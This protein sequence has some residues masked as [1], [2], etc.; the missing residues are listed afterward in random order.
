MSKE[1]PS[2]SPILQILHLEDSP[3][4]CD[5]VQEAV[6]ND[7]L[8]GEFTRVATQ[9]E[10]VDALNRVK[11]DVI[12]ADY[13][14]PGY[15]GTAALG[16]ARKLQP[17]TP[18]IFVSGTI[19]EERAV[20]ILKEGAADCV[21]KTRFSRLGP[22]IRRALQ[23]SHERR[24]RRQAEH[25]LRESEA[26]FREMAEN[27]REV[28]WSA[29]ADGGEFHYV[30][31]AYERIWRQPV[32]ALL[33]WPASWMDSVWAE[34]QPRVTLARKRLAEGT[35]CDHE[36]RILQPDGSCRW[37][38]E[39]AYPVRGALG[40]VERMVGVARDITERKQLEEQLQQ[41]QKMESIGQ[42]AGGIA[43]DFSN[44]LTVINGYSHMLLDQQALPPAIAESLRMIFVAGGRAAALTRQL[45]IFSRKNHAH[46]QLVD[47]NEL[48][49]DV[50]SMLRR[51]IGENI[52][53]DLDL[54]HPLPKIHA[55]ASMMEQILM[56]LVVNARDAMPRGGNIVVGSG[57]CE[58]TSADCERNREARLGAYVWLSVRDTGCG[59]PP[60]IL[61]RIFEPF[62]TTKGA[63]L[64]TGLGL[65]TVFGIVKQHQGWVEVESDVG[66]GSLF[67]VFLP[68]TTVTDSTPPRRPTDSPHVTG[69]QETILLVEDEESVR[70]FARTVLQ[71]HGYKVLEAGSGVEALETWKWYRARISLLLTDM[72]M[73]GDMSGQELAQTLQTDRPELKVLFSSGYNPDM[74]R[75]V[76]SPQGSFSF[77][78]KPYQPKTLTRMVREILDRGV[79]AP[80]SSSQAPFG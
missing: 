12:L 56:N 1:S 20:D 54:A 43:H 78:Q 13:S 75:Q 66:N 42:L 19:G 18:F 10:F 33:A 6:R 47:L 53:L 59:I 11:F 38:E 7:G 4:D 23:G 44:M 60:E 24:A 48:V 57:S 41:A 22:A 31:A 29:S 64:G 32:A 58:T 55:D 73:P 28:F 34:D 25:A 71:M 26:R 16:Q 5:L 67:R 45:L 3:A 74:A 65:A 39:R 9:E 14:L 15:D 61:P 72:V 2:A 76:L 63:G 69:G 80:A 37:I 30:S 21:L 40:R 50:A 62:F 77:L 79:A 8:L 17:E 51:M 70:A 49:T 52:R 68:I 27:I 35:P 46:H 36:Y